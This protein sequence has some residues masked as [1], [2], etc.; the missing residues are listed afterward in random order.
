MTQS[1]QDYGFRHDPMEW[2]EN[3]ASLEAAMARVN[4][5]QQSKEGDIDIVRDAAAELLA[6]LRQELDLGDPPA[7]PHDL[8]EVAY[9][10]GLEEGAEIGRLVLSE[11]K[12]DD[13]GSIG[14]YDLIALCRAG[15]AE[16]PEVQASVEKL[17]ARTLEE[18]PWQTCPWG[19]FLK[20][21]AL[22]YGRDVAETGPALDHLINALNNPANAIG[23]V[24]DKDP[25]SFIDV[26][27]V[28][29]HPLARTIVE[30][31]IPMILRAQGADGGWGRMSFKVLRALHRHGLI[32][33]LRELPPLPADW[34]IVRSI[35][36]PADDLFTM[37][38]DGERLWVCRPKSSELIAVSPE[39]GRVLKT[40][41][42]A[43]EKIGGI[44][45]WDGALA[46]TQNEPKRLLKVDAESGEVVHTIPLDSPF[47]DFGGVAQVG[48][49][50]L[51]CDLFMPC[52]WECDPAGEDKPLFRMLGGPGPQGLCV[53]NGVVW[54]FDWL[55]PLLVGSNAD[56]ELVDYGDVPFAGDAAGIAHD[57]QNLW[58]LDNEERRICMIEKT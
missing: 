29:E 17:A 50:L 41:K 30:R 22:W 28:V 27:G 11:S 48:E 35:P 46:V 12:R 5:F 40:L 36:A 34:R 42:L 47:D 37:T 51:V 21:R 18:N 20:M 25:K 39:D 49:A 23:C 2:V 1:Q 53:Q 10:M 56:G 6:K 7:R 19:A 45:S 9:A 3:D 58:V 13:D 44:G 57:G 15:L 16:E 52:V 54:H 26:G 43:E 33:T 24:C 55:I 4:V 8:I 14:T 31:G 32:E 38:S